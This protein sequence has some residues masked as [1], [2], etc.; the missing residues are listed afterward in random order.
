MDFSDVEVEFP[1]K[2][3]P[4]RVRIKADAL[5]LL[6][7]GGHGSPEAL[8]AANRELIEELVALTPAGADGVV[9]IR[10]IDIEG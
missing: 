2:G 10:A 9:E 6:W 3:G 5:R 1:A 8:V 4:I 7:G